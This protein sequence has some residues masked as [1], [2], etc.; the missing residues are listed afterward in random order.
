MEFQTEDKIYGK[1]IFIL[2]L[3]QSITKSLISNDSENVNMWN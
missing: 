1:L 3:F 2:I